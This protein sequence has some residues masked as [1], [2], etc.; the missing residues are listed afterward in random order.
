MPGPAPTCECR[1]PRRWSHHD[2]KPT[3]ARCLRPHEHRDGASAIDV[4][5]R[6][7]GWL[8]LI[9]RS[10]SNR[11]IAAALF[12][13]EGAVKNHVTSILTKLDVGDRT[14]AALRARELGLG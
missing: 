3:D 5:S 4:Y 8:R 9:A 6:S 11:E 14:Q 2:G 10:A 13:A 1:P 12:L 7:T